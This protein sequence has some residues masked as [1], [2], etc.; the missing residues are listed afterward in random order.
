[1]NNKELL[2]KTNHIRD[3]GKM[4]RTYHL[5]TSHDTTIFVGEEIEGDCICFFS[6]C[7]MAK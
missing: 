3:K 2:I 5:E 6:V 4:R 1:M 7:V